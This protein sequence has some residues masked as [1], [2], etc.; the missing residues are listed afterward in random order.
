MHQVTNMLEHNAYVRCL[1]VDFYKAFDRVDHL[2]LVGKLSEIQISPFIFNWLILF[3][4]GI[5]RTTRCFD[6]EFCSMPINL[7]IVQGSVLG[8]IF[9]ILLEGDLKPI[10]I[11]D[12]IFKYADDTNLFVPEN[13]DV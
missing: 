6:V 11:N 5:S 9:Y 3:L 2:I 10:S 7:S 4:T 8:P 13:T 1:L 12:I